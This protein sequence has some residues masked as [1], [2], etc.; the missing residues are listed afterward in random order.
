MPKLQQFELHAS[1]HSGWQ[2]AARRWQTWADYLDALK[3]ALDTGVGH[4][5]KEPRG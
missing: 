1:S 2:N 5:G 3:V 4:D